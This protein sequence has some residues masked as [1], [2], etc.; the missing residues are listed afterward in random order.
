MNVLYY[1]FFYTQ[2][3]IFYINKI[4]RQPILLNVPNYILSQYIFKIDILEMC[5]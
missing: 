1:T 4:N 2:G 5:N 3:V